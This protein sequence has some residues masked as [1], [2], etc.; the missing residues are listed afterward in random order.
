VTK[1]EPIYFVKNYLQISK[2]IFRVQNA[3]TFSPDTE[4]YV[5]RSLN[6]D[7]C[8]QVRI[9]RLSRAHAGEG[10]TMLSPALS[11]QNWPDFR[12][13]PGSTAGPNS[14]TLKERQCLTGML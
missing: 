6:V 13:N 10:V 11:Q 14:Q 4:D 3:L 5:Q 2:T 8:G 1:Y 7:G 12:S 9:K